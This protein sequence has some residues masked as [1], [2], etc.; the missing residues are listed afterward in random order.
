MVDPFA[1]TS[2]KWRGICAGRLQGFAKSLVRLW[3]P[4]EFEVSRGD[5]PLFEP[6]QA[7]V[8]RLAP[9]ALVQ[10]IGRQEPHADRGQHAARTERDRQRAKRFGIVTQVDIV[11]RSV[12]GHE[13]QADHL[14]GNAAETSASAMRAGRNRASQGLDVDVALVLECQ[15]MGREWFANVVQLCASQDRGFASGRVDRLDACQVIERNQQ[16]AGRA[17]RLERVPAATDAD[18][19]SGPGGLADKLRN[20]RF[21]RW[22]VRSQADCR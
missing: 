7:L 9:G 17:Q 1:F 13:A 21:A 14:R 3:I 15:A 22:A 12:T 4:E 11:Q 2:I 16:I 20:L 8:D 18:I 19:L 5:D 10:S 6:R